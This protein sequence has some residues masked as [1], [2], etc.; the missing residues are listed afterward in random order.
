MYKREL[1]IDL[2]EIFDVKKV[3]FADISY[4]AEQDVLY[5]DISA[6]KNDIKNGKEFAQFSGAVSMLAADEKL[7]KGWFH[8]RIALMNKEQNQKFFFSPQE[9]NIPFAHIANKLL[10]KSSVSF[11]YFYEGEFNPPE[12][13]QGVRG[14][15]PL[16]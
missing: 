12:K 16:L 7:Q 3:I 15:C 1:E 6:T 11:M 9:D 2:L 4:G 8:K 13:L 14:Q 5:C 10:S